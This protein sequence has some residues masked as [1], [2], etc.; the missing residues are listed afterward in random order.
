M[1]NELTLVNLCMLL[2]LE[3]E[4]NRG[5]HLVEDWEIQ[6]DLFDWDCGLTIHFS[7]KIQV[8]F[9][10]SDIPKHLLERKDKC[11][12]FMEDVSRY[13]D[14]TAWEKATKIN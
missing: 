14:S 12:N 5:T 4:L 1:N 3:P 13:I 11:P 7:H 9:E 6:Q 8:S 10:K 2:G